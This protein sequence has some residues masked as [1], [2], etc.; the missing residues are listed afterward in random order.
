MKS[1]PKH[2][3]ELEIYLDSLNCNFS[4]IGLTE[5][6]LDDSKEALHDISNYTCLHRYRQNRK[7]GGVT[8]TVRNGVAFKVRNDLEFVHSVTDSIFIEVEKNIFGT[9][10]NLLIGVIC[11]MPDSSV[12]TFNDQM[13]DWLNI[14]QRERKI[15]YVL[16]DLNLDLLKH[17]EHRPSSAFLDILYSY[18][19]YPLISKPTRV[20]TNSATLI[21]H[22]LT[23]NFDVN[24]KH[25]QGI[26]I[27]KDIQRTSLFHDLTLNNG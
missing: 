20:T 10:S 9:S 25:K 23:N 26:K 17:E 1:L 4:L 24:C 16:G 21:D 8:I 6:W 12:E 13:H 19:V 2:Q 5:T 7:G 14:I 18:S 3:N 11:R 22:I 15:C 27:Q